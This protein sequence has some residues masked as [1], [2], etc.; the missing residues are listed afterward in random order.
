MAHRVSPATWHTQNFLHH[1]RLVERLIHMARL[2][3]RDT[4]LDLGAGR[5]CNHKLLG[6]PMPSRRCRRGRS[7]SGRW[8]APSVSRHAQRDGSPGGCIAHASAAR[9]LQSVCQYSLRRYCPRAASVD[10]GH[11]RATGEL[12]GGSARSRRADCWLATPD[13]VFSPALPVV[14]RGRHPPLP[15]HRLSAGA[16]SRRGISTTPQTW[17]PLIPGPHAALYRGL[18]SACFVGRPD[19]TLASTLEYL[20]G[21]RRFLRLM[22]ELGVSATATPSTVGCATWLALFRTIANDATVRQKTALLMSP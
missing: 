16:A 21:H 4:V 8:S 19:R 17:A 22:R 13:V 6:R 5:R 2:S 10:V 12:L 14:R 18:V 11:L 7:C 20:L 3:E 15:A 1:R 9:T